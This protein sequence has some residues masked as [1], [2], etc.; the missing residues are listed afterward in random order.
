[1][2]ALQ[3]RLE[4]HALTVR[5]FGQRVAIV[6]TEFATADQVMPGVAEIALEMGFV[7]ADPHTEEIRRGR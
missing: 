7:F 6:G 1:M 3:A 5:K 4:G 2:E